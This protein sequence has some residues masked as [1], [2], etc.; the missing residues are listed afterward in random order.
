MRT[1]RTIWQRVREGLNTGLIGN[2]KQ[3]RG[4]GLRGAWL[5]GEWRVN[6]KVLRGR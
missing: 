6:G 3:V 1:C 2:G 5:A 4:V